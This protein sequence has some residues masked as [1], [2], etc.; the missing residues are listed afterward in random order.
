MSFA[1]AMTSDQERVRALLA[2]T[3]G[4]L[5]RKGL[6]YNIGLKV[7]GLIGITLDNEQVLLVHIN[8]SYRSSN[9]GETSGDQVIRH[10]IVCVTR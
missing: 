1:M 8:E 7:Q 2:E 10:S 6:Q 9:T 4:L 5:C 3:V